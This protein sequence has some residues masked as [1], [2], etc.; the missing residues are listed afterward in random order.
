MFT[1]IIIE[2]KPN[3]F[4]DWNMFNVSCV[5]VKIYKELYFVK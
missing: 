2:T 1:K 4:E 5:M 3:I